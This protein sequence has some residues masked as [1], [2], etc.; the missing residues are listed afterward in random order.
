M[1]NFAPRAKQTLA[2]ARKGTNRLKQNFVGTEH[3]LS[4]PW[5]GTRGLDAGGTVDDFRA[6]ESCR[7]A[8]NG[9]RLC[10]F[11]SQAG[12]LFLR[13]AFDAVFFFVARILHSF[14]LSISC[15]PPQQT[16]TVK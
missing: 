1:N 10:V 15:N 16:L 3:L 8:T 6:L 7:N 9:H 12:T 2:L 5:I 4:R 13:D 14:S 11:L